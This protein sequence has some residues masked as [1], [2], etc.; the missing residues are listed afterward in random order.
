MDES[1][2]THVLAHVG[3]VDEELGAEVFLGD[4]LVVG[5]GDGAYAGQDQ[6]LCDLVGEG[7]DVDEQ[8]V[9]IADAILRLEAPEADLPVV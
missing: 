2:G 5:E 9:G 8:D 4:V 1:E 3:F 6:V 7:L